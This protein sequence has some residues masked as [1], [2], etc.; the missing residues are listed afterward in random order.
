MEGFAFSVMDAPAV[1]QDSG[2][3]GLAVVYG[4]RDRP[5]RGFSRFEEAR[6]QWLDLLVH[7][8]DQLSRVARG[9]I[10]ARGN[11]GDPAVHIVHQ[12]PGVGFRGPDVVTQP[13]D[14]Y[15]HVF[16]KGSGVRQGYD[17][18]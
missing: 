11:G 14:L 1:E 5:R 3:A 2:F 18:K 8:F 4:P 15:I 6:G 16:Q 12:L 9:R 10:H 7:V 13:G 17:K